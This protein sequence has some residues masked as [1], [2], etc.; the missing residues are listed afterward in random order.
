[1]EGKTLRPETQTSP[2]PSRPVPSPRY[3]PGGPVPAHGAP[4]PH[5][6]PSSLSARVAPH[7]S[8][9]PSLMSWP[10]VSAPS[11]SFTFF[12]PELRCPLDRSA[13]R[14]ATPWTVRPPRAH[15]PAAQCSPR[16]LEAMRR[17]PGSRSAVSA[18]HF[19]R[20]A[21]PAVILAVI[22]PKPAR[23]ESPATSF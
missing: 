18:I 8:P 2:P 12:L 9:S 20:R 1:M 11:P 17:A 23:R 7:A 10:H 14:P 16:L 21:S 15:Q 5:S 6:R 13:A 22:S 19:P 4:L 3:G